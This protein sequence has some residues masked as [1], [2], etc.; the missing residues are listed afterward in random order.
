MKKQPL[1]TNNKNS[2]QIAVFEHTDK[3]GGTWLSTAIKRHYK[4]ETGSGSMA[5]LTGNNS[6]HLGSSVGLFFVA[7]RSAT[8][9]PNDYQLKTPMIRP[10]LSVT[11]ICE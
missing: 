4:T 6:M 8:R 2:V 3:N 10:A 5:A 1:L 11:G 7:C 9:L